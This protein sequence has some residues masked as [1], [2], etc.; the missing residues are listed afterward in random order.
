MIYLDSR[1]NRLSLSESDV[2]KA[3]AAGELLAIKHGK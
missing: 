3:P 1:F 2:H